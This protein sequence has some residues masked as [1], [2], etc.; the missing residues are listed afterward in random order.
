M[1]TFN[2]NIQMMISVGHPGILWILYPSLDVPKRIWISNS[3]FCTFDYNKILGII[4]SFPINTYQDKL[5]YPTGVQLYCM[6]CYVRNRMSELTK[7]LNSNKW[8]H[9]SFLCIFPQPLDTKIADSVQRSDHTTEQCPYF[10]LRN[11]H[12]AP[13]ITR[14]CVWISPCDRGLFPLINATNTHIGHGHCAHEHI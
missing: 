12:V 10:W 1:V 7:L 3:A 13:S 14:S 5:T 6:S 4:Y 8:K 9:S 11:T 2:T